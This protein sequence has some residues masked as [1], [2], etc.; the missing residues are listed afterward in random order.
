MSRI[1]KDGISIL[2]PHLQIIKTVNL[3]RFFYNEDNR[4][5]EGIPRY[6]EKMIMIDSYTK[7]GEEAFRPTLKIFS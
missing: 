3:K 4:V 6:V 5:F 1:P 7:L 2:H